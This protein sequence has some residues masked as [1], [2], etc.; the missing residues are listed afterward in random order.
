MTLPAYGV[1]RGKL[2]DWDRPRPSHTPPQ[3][4]LLHAVGRCQR[5][6]WSARCGGSC[7]ARSRAGAPRAPTTREQTA[8]G[9]PP[10]IHG[11]AHSQQLSSSGPPSKRARLCW[12]FRSPVAVVV[13]QHTA[14]R[15]SRRACTHSY[16][17]CYYSEP[18]VPAM[19]VGSAG[20]HLAGQLLSMM[21]FIV[22][23]GCS[24]CG[25]G[26]TA[27]PQSFVSTGAAHVIFCGLPKLL[28]NP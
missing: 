15:A 7:Y 13:R 24:Q 20:K 18:S 28:A 8:A 3:M 4:T 5:R 12:P 25:P 17:L 19:E 1:E 10:C 14:R 26:C 16:P 22:R 11:P 27:L 21:V 6:R 23:A 2:L 9:S